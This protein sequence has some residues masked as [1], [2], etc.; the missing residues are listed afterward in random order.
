MP[1]IEALEHL[2][3]IRS[4]EEADYNMNKINQSIE[5]DSMLIAA[6]HVNGGNSQEIKEQREAHSKRLNQ[7]IGKDQ[8]KES[9][10]EMEQYQWSPEV[11]AQLDKI[12]ERR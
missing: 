4:K 11:Q 1:I 10:K 6:L 8:E 7:F 5:F 12:N 9:E 3:L 2:L